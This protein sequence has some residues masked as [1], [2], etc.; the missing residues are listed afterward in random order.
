MLQVKLPVVDRIHPLSNT[1]AMSM[2]NK[3]TGDLQLSDRP[4]VKSRSV[5]YSLRCL[6]TFNKIN[7]C[8]GSQCFFFCSIDM[9][10]IVG[11]LE[12]SVAYRQMRPTSHHFL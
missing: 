2:E 11:S 4:D 6:P 8:K 9:Q 7:N 5:I 10:R 12:K 1:F 3:A